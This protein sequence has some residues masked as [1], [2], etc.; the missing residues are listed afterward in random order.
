MSSAVSL[1]IYFFLITVFTTANQIQTIREYVNYDIS[2][3]P[4]SR[5][6]YIEENE[7]TTTDSDAKKMKPATLVKPIPTGMY[8]PMPHLSWMKV[9]PRPK[10]HP[11]IEETTDIEPSKEDTSENYQPTN[12]ATPSLSKIPESTPAPNM[13]KETKSETIKATPTTGS[14]SNQ[15]QQGDAS[16]YHPNYGHDHHHH[17]YPHPEEHD[18]HHHY[19]HHHP[20]HHHHH[21]PP[22][23]HHHHHDYHEVHHP[24]VIVKDHHHHEP[25]PLIVVKEKHIHHFHHKPYY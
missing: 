1:S 20:Y 17:H 23:P 11:E 2:L 21:P 3:R 4:N 25:E 19:G 24:I 13:E 7:E 18:E 14:S 10:R 9:K 16:F 5:G 6:E 15:T 22:H 8:Q 12:Q